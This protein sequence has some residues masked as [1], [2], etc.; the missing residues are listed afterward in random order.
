ML[1]LGVVCFVA[2]FN[3]LKPTEF[4][5]IN[6]GH[7]GIF[8]FDGF[9]VAEINYF[10]C[11]IDCRVLRYKRQLNGLI[12]TFTLQLFAAIVWWRA[13]FLY[14]RDFWGNDEFGPM[15]FETSQIINNW[16]VLD[17]SYFKTN[18]F[19]HLWK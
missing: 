17:V 2:R 8:I 10:L 7:R 16:T 5:C 4:I 15:Q 1:L 11:G 14:C 3:T 12:R 19:G 13:E 6:N 9:I 18:G